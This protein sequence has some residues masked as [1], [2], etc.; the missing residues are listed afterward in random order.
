MGPL[1]PTAPDGDNLLDG[2]ADTAG[3][4]GPVQY[5]ELYCQPWGAGARGEILFYFL[6][7]RGD[8]VANLGRQVVRRRVFDILNKEDVEI[9][10]DEEIAVHGRTHIVW[11]FKKS[12]GL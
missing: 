11:T 3:A 8:R 5:V 9:N 2:E 7:I 1:R 6:G 10:N 4:L 12:A